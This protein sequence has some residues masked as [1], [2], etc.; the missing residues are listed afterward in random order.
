MQKEIRCGNAVGIVDTLGGEMIS[1]VNSGKEY[2]WCGDANHWTGHAPVLF[3]F[4]SALKEN[5]VRYDGV[6]YE[7]NG[8]HGFARKTEFEVVSIE[9]NKAVFALKSNETTKKYYPYDFTLTVTHE[10]C[11]CGYKT[12][13]EVTNT[14]SKP[15]RFCIGG[16][17]GFAVE[18]SIE[19]YELVFETEE[20]CALYYT[21]KESLFSD[22]YVYDGNAVK[23]N[24]YE[25]RYSDYDV[26]AL[27]AK[28]IKSRKVKLVRRDNGKGIEFD[29]S[30]FGVLVIWTPPKKNSPFLCLEPWNGLPAYTDE[31]GEFADKPYAITL[32]AGKTYSASY[33]VKLV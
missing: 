1:Y 29:Y 15:I 7:Y 20:D 25:L 24:K 27:I 32:E 9:G 16:H 2:I 3:P 18:N 23:G 14:D 26:D 11:E 13:Y 22:S 8:K 5:K 30:D 19:D 4:V 6:E 12:T 31:S 17:P 10:I 33:K 21:D 28:D